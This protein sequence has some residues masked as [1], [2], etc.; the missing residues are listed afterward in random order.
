[1]LALIY[2]L[3][4]LAMCAGWLWQRRQRNA[5]IVDVVW[6]ASLACAALLAALLG[7]GAISARLLVALCGALWG[8]RL[9]HHLWRR[10]RAEGEDGRYRALR[11]RW[12]EAPWKWFALFQF[13]AA[14][15]ALFS[16]PFVIVA[17]NVAPR[18]ALLLAAAALWCTS[19]ALE[20]RADAE[21][22][23][24]RANPANRGRACREGLWRYSRH[25]NYFFEWLHW[26]TYALAA[27]GAAYA[28]VAWSGPL[29]M[30]FFLRY[31]SGI[32]FTEAQALRTRGEDYR[33]YQAST[34][35]LFPWPPKTPSALSPRSENDEHP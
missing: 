7:R 1:M 15:V 29:L 19:V 12:G 2:A 4:A 34:P 17:L 24:F 14:L 27:T 22:A 31:L 25:P 20:V 13:Q 16:V 26:F 6:S 23:R 8:A 5:G 21:L 10:V 9:A 35:M 18:P 3:A 28:W 30:Y 33:D 32:P 11:A